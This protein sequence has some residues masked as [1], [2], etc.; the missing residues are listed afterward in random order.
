MRGRDETEFVALLVSGDTQ[1][2]KALVE[3]NAGWMLRLAKRFTKS[4]AAA[5]DCVQESFLL[6]FRKI[7]DFEGRSPLRGWIRSIVVN[8]ALMKQRQ[9]A[10]SDEQPLENWAPEFDHNGFLIGPVTIANDSASALVSQREISNIVQMAIG[11]LPD[12]YRAV[13]LLRDIE[14]YSTR[15]AADALAISE[16]A[17]RTRL[18][19]GRSELK[20][21]LLP[22]MGPQTL[23][24][25]I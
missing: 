11:E 20:R 21:R 14:G 15:E 3:E 10:Q 7:G 5:A 24:E 9:R 19:R 16:G 8:Q 23:D 18:H 17:V 6:I 4:E 12:S 2:F 1:A 22:T 25:I 13:L